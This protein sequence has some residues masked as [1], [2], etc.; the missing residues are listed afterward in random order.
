MFQEISPIEQ[1]PV[2]HDD[3]VFTLTIG[4]SLG[5]TG[6]PT[7]GVASGASA[8]ANA[9]LTFQCHFIIISSSTMKLI[10]YPCRL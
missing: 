2:V 8:V 10:Y 1:A 5:N 7:S 4:P 9:R 3:G 6:E